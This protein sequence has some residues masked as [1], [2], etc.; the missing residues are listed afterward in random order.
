[1]QV[2]AGHRH[3]VYTDLKSDAQ[4]SDIS[5]V[6]EEV[7]LVALANS[8]GIPIILVPSASGLPMF[9]LL[10]ELFYHAEP[11]FIFVDGTPRQYLPIQIVE[12]KVNK[13]FVGIHRI[14]L[15]HL[16]LYFCL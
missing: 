9:P 8:V 3:V 4:I 2:T 15:I 14:H 11:V 1:M 13:C 16:F 6:P 7:L 5:A 12:P 10:P